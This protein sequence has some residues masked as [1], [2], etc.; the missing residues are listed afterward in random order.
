MRGVDDLDHQLLVLNND[1]VM[2]SS[3]GVRP[4]QAD[5]RTNPNVYKQDQG[6]VLSSS[7]QARDDC[8]I[9]GGI[10]DK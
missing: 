8:Q 5:R 9:N 4:P 6:D 3:F 10:S 2:S 1:E 7:Q